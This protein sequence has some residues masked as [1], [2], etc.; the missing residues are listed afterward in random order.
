M[1]SQCF[2]VTKKKMSRMTYAER[3]KVLESRRH[4]RGKL[5]RLTDDFGFEDLGIDWLGHKDRRKNDKTRP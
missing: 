1:V 3:L 2:K 5:T 4:N